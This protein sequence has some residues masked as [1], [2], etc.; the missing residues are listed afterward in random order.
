VDTP[1]L[2]AISQLRCGDIRGLETLV[3]LHQLKAVRTAY[4]ITGSREAAEDIVADAY[5][6]VYDRIGQLRESRP[7]APWFYRIVVNGALKAVRKARWT[8]YNDNPDL[9]FLDYLADTSPG[10]EEQAT[11]KE[12]RALLLGAVYSLPAQQR[13]ALVLRYYLDMDEASIAHALGCPLG[14]VKWRLHAAKKRLRKSLSP[15]L[16][17]LA[18][19][20]DV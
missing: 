4:A 7:F 3:R 6:K 17:L 2:T 14:T 1:E 12:M 20:I 16:E 10:P 5:L 15:H 19:G 8:S 13:A 11:H 9:D 18:P